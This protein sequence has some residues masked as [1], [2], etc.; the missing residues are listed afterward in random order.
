MQNYHKKTLD[1]EAPG[2]SWEE[3]GC[4]PKLQRGLWEARGRGLRERVRPPEGS[5]GP[6]EIEKRDFGEGDVFPETFQTL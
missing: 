3:L 1:L 4:P 6:L 5:R 2:R